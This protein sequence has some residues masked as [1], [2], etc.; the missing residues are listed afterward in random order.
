MQEARATHCHLDKSWHTSPTH[1]ASRSPCRSLPHRPTR[2]APPARWD[3]I[4]GGHCCSVLSC[5]ASS[6]AFTVYRRGVQHTGY[7]SAGDV[8][9]ELLTAAKFMACLH[10]QCEGDF[11]GARM[12]YLQ[13]HLAQ[14]MSATSSSEEEDMEMMVPGEGVEE[15]LFGQHARMKDALGEAID[16]CG[17][18]S[19]STLWVSPPRALSKCHC[20]LHHNF[21][22]QISGRKRVVL[23]APSQARFLYLHPLHH[24]LDMRPRVDLRAPDLERFPKLAEAE[25]LEAILE[26]GQVLFLP[27]WWW[28]EIETLDGGLDQPGRGASISINFWF[29]QQQEHEYEQMALP[30]SADLY[31]QLARDVEQLIADRIGVHQVPAFLRYLLPSAGSSSKHLH[32]EQTLG[33][34][35]RR[36]ASLAQ[37]IVSRVDGLLRARAAKSDCDE[38]ECSSSG[39]KAWAFIE[40]YLHPERF[41][42]LRPA[43]RQSAQSSH[44]LS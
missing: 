10:R 12:R 30:L 32:A 29:D 40:Q 7:A 23:L 21:L 11:Q 15:W 8:S 43:V 34:D 25:S 6:P 18:W 1:P 36:W 19:L 37:T 24:P 38:D 41:E 20:D 31:V 9:V 27:R 28:H 33:S 13:T 5:P 44:S 14:R 22:C 26:P 35:C 39:N 3:H 16:S 17:S 4:V 42:G 2:A